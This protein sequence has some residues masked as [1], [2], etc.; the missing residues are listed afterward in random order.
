MRPDLE[1]DSRGRLEWLLALAQGSAYGGP[2][3]FLSA[4]RKVFSLYG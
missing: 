1:A 3:R 4:R 2:E